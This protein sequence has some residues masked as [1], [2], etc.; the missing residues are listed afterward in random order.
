M[1]ARTR[2]LALLRALGAG[3]LKT[4]LVA[5]AEASMIAAAALAAGAMA[6]WLLIALAARELMERFGLLLT[7]HF[8]LRNAAYVIA[9][10]AVAAAAA[11]LFPAIRAAR[12]PIEE[13]LQS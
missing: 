1:N 8:E 9:G 10:T 12:T 6:T 2:D 3:P 13:L 11:A 5:F 4:G 7:P